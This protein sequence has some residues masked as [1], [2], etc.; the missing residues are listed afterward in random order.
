[1]A[2]FATMAENPALQSAAATCEIRVGRL[3]LPGDLV[4]PSNAEALVVFAYGSGSSRMSPRNRAVARALNE[5]RV[6]TLLFDLLTP[7]EERD[8]GNVFTRVFLAGLAF[9]FARYS[10]EDAHREG[11]AAVVIEDTCRVAS[12]STD[13]L[14]RRGRACAI[15]ASRA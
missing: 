4:I 13:R 3:A 5:R 2:I 7:E 9:D 8:R 6:E 11:F 15:S 1:M 12:I 14:S 10:A